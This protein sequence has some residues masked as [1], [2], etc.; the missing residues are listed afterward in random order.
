M[1]NSIPFLMKSRSYYWSAII[2]SIH[3]SDYVLQEIW[4]EGRNVYAEKI[5]N[6]NVSGKSDIYLDEDAEYM[7]RLIRRE[8]M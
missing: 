1:G 2:S 7:R 6:Q 8:N 4:G 5:L 3:G